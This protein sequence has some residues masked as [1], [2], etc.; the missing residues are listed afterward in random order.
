MKATG[1]ARILTLA[2]A[3]GVGKTT[4]ARALA[5]EF[6]T[7]IEVADANPQLQKFLKND[8]AFNAS[9][10]QNW[11]LNQYDSALASAI[12][13]APL[14]LDQDPIGV[15][16]VYARLFHEQQSL[17][18]NDYALLLVRLLNLES[19]ILDWS[20]GRIMLLLDAPADV[21]HERVRQRGYRRTPPLEWFEMLRTY[22]ARLTD[23]IPSVHRI[24]TSEHSIE[25]V[26]AL[27]RSL[28]QV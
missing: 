13:T 9:A 20:G 25:F 21:L 19:R 5:M 26:V 28:L 23:G 16:R 14:V 10:N 4:I 15:V 1:T 17:S 18:S 22:F 8:P 2:G 3:S 24:S 12:P 27:A 7:Y 11:F 6:P